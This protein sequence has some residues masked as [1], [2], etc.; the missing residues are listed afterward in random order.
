MKE[1]SRK[2]RWGILGYAQIAREAFIP[3]LQASANGEF[4]ALAS[5]EP[6]R[7]AACQERYRVPRTYE[8]YEALLRDPEV[9]AV[10]VPLPNSLHREWTLKAAAH[11][12]HVL[13]EKP[14]ALHAG[15]CRDMVEGCAAGGVVFME[16]F[17]Y[18]YSSRLRQVLEVLHSG[19]LGE[20]RQI[21]ATFRFLLTDPNA[22]NLRPELGGGSLYDVGCYPV[23]LI[24]LVVD[25][26]AGEAPGAG[27]QPHSVAAECVRGASG[28][29]LTFAALLRYPSGLVAT[30]SSGFDSHERIFAELIGTRGVLEVPNVFFGP[31]EPMILFADGNRRSMP[32]AVED[33]Y[34]L[35][36][37]DFAD[38]ILTRR[39]PRLSLRETQRNTEV[40]D[41]LRAAMSPP[42]PA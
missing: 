5:R 28:V 17:M 42:A 39:S 21:N 40:I 36:A 7:L 24:G 18:R 23:N 22:F 3:A 15:E 1:G 32:V 27:G 16:A 2:I 13:C 19:V 8:D 9:D 14:I 4:Y 30:I 37:E 34:R 10:Y 25:A 11:G 38:A 41:R 33:C 12:K 20:L 31:A 29:D 26:L 35:E 6:A